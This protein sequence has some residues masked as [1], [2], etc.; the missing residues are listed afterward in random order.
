MPRSTCWL[1]VSICCLLFATHAA[2][3][4][5][6]DIP[7]F[8]GSFAEAVA[9]AKK[10]R[11]LLIVYMR[12]PDR[13]GEDAFDK[14][15]NHTLMNRS[16]QQWIQWHGVL[17]ELRYEED[18]DT[19][20][21]LESRIGTPSGPGQNVG[22]Q[23]NMRR[24]PYF[25]IFRNG[26][27]EEV[28]PRPYLIEN[29]LFDSGVGAQFIDDIGPEQDPRDPLK[30]RYH[31]M[32]GLQGLTPPAEP[33]SDTAYVKPLEL[34]LQLDIY[35]DRLRAKEPVWVGQHD[36]K[37]PPPRAPDRLFFA[38]AAD[39]DASPWPDNGQIP[40]LWSS[41]ALAR[42]HAKDGDQ[43]I[44]T[45]IYTWIWERGTDAPWLAP[46]R[47]T[48]IASE[49]TALAAARPGAK[50]RFTRMRDNGSDRYAWADFIE[51]W[52]WLILCEIIGDPF[53]TL[54]ELDYSL[55][56]PDEGSLATTT[57]QSGLRL[58][59]QR[60]PWSDVWKVS[61]DDIKRLDAIRNLER[62]KPAP[63]ATKE[64]WAELVAF[65]R[66]VLLSEACRIHIA[67]LRNRSDTQAMRIATDLIK[68]DIDGSARLALA[69]MAWAAGLAD[70]R[71]IAWVKEAITLGA[72]DRGLLDTM[73]PATSVPPS[74]TSD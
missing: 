69:S 60:S 10:E 15:A 63:R 29:L 35:L 9:Y 14:V 41:L 74:T 37:N 20:L 40:T 19:F 16:L 50:S 26:E 39:P 67:S 55:N 21:R 56:D 17:T 47:R 70:E 31:W 51:R 33:L 32:K 62:Q 11:R 53:E 64:E 73:S 13:R 66:A 3:Q 23:F 72:D 36:L 4:I 8:N 49:M 65:R 22:G 6:T 38:S 7:Y 44:A 34:L 5:P 27:F 45:G 12:G 57:E 1:L 46:L 2:A 25:A 59:S 61:S 52:E 42:E 54:L 18:P 28:V 71:H 24:D 68:H 30:G 48:L 43:H 58:L